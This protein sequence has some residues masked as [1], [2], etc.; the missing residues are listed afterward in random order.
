MQHNKAWTLPS[1]SRTVIFPWNKDSGAFSTDFDESVWAHYQISQQDISQIIS[2]I[3]NEYKLYIQG[4]RKY[5]K[6]L[7]LYSLQFC[8]LLF[9]HVVFLKIFLT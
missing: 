1:T 8:K 2:Q 9:S 4:I 7:Y 3:S 6:H 5:S